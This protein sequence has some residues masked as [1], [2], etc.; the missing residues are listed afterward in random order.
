VQS[1]RVEKYDYEVPGIAVHGGAAMIAINAPLSAVKALI[2]DYAHYQ[3]IMPGFSRSRVI[4]KSAVGTDVY[5]QVPVLHGAATLWAVT[6][7]SPPHPD[8]PGERIDAHRNGQANV[9]DF[10][11][12]WRYYAVDDAHTVLKLEVLMIPVVPLPGALLTPQLEQAAGEALL[13]LRSRAESRA[14]AGN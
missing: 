13:A 12:A 14:V 4:A 7:F 3:D 6:R 10:R 9:E 8:G 5:L 2:T 1:R 11:A